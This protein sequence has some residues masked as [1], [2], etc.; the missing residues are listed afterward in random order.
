MELLKQE[1]EK[2][3]DSILN[4]S[5]ISDGICSIILD[6]SKDI[7]CRL[8]NIKILLKEITTNIEQIKTST[9]CIENNI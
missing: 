7:L 6:D 2:I 3:S 4:I 9:A 5:D 8:S 1:K